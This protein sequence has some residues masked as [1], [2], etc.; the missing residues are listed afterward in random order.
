VGVHLIDFEG[1]F[2]NKTVDFAPPP[3]P[4]NLTRR[5]FISRGLEEGKE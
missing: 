4:L 3:P 1:K 5:P 2:A